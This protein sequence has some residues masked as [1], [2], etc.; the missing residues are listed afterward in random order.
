MSSPLFRL[1]G[2]PRALGSVESDWMESVIQDGEVALALDDRGFDAASEFG[3]RFGFAALR[4][5]REETSAEEREATV[6]QY[7]GDLALIWIAEGF[8][9]EARTWA[10]AR[11]PMTLLVES[12]S[13]LESE[14]QRRIER[15]IAIIG[16]QID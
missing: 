16:R 1:V 4:V 11:P 15:F 12:G 6:R 10:K 5:L 3:H 8:S 14:Q 13:E 2:S 7:A 9:D